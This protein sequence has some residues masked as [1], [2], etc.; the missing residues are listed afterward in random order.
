MN[1]LLLTAFLLFIIPN[2]SESFADKQVEIK[3]DQNIR[4]E[5]STFNR[6]SL[7]TGE[8]ITELGSLTSIIIESLGAILIVFFIIV[9]AIKKRFAKKDTKKSE[10]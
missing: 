4:I 10:K 9:Y 6:Q 1:H 3:I 2:M 5:D 8:T 7:Q